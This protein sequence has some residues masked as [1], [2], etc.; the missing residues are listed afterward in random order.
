[1]EASLLKEEAILQAE[2]NMLVQRFTSTTGLISDAGKK[3]EA[4]FRKI[5]EN[6]PQ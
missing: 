1:M 2:L 5:A 3:L 4:L 6:F